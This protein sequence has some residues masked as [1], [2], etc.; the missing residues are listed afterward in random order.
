MPKVERIPPKTPRKI[1]YKVSDTISI[2][3]ERLGDA[4]R[5]YYNNKKIS[6]VKGSFVEWCFNVEE[7]NIC[8]TKDELEAMLSER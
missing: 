3:L 1:S 8:F 2:D 6:E 7:Y 5:S 4:Y